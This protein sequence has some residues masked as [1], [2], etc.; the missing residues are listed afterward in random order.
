MQTTIREES[1]SLTAKLDRVGSILRW[2]GWSGVWV[3]LGLAVVAGV[4]LSFAI[5]GRNFN[6]AVMTTPGGVAGAVPGAAYNFTDATTPGIGVGIFWAVCGIL[7]LLFSAYLAFKQT[8]FSRRLRN[9]NS[10]VHPGKSEVMKVL[11]LGI[12][13]GFVGMLFTILGGST[14]LGVLLSKTIAQAQ[15]VTIYDPTRIIRS[16]DVFV[17]MANMV[18]IAAHFTGVI[19][20][21]GTF[22]WLHHQ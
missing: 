11:R 17:A 4:M 8:R 18:G 5:A 22:N 3:Q 6:Q 21:I 14:T 1:D 20:S 10:A 15:G 7:A 12:I 19:A 9:Q 16:L 2:V 13:V